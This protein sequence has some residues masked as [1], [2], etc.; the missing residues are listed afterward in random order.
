MISAVTS[1]VAAGPLDWLWQAI[2]DAAG[3]VAGAVLVV[4][5]S[6]ADFVVQGLLAHV[7]LPLVQSTLFAPVSLAHGAGAGVVGQAAWAVW[8]TAAAASPAVALVSLAWGGWLTS[9]F[10]AVGREKPALAEGLAVWALTLVGGYA[11]LQ[12]LLAAANTITQTLM[13]ASRSLLANALTASAHPAVDLA[14][15]V[16][17]V[18]T[19]LFQPLA[20]LILSGLLLW[21]VV[22]WVMRQ[23]EIVVFVGILPV[24]AALALSGNRRAWQWAWAE[25]QGAVFTQLAMAVLWWIAWLLLGGQLPSL[26]TGFGPDLGRLL[27]AAGALWMV[28]QA[29]Q[30]VR[31][32]TGHQH[33]G[34]GG[35]MLGMAAGALL[36]RNTR[37]AFHMS[38]MGAALHGVVQG[39]LAAAEQKALEGAQGPSLGERLA[40]TTV[41]QAVAP[42]W[43][44]LH[45]AAQELSARAV[46]LTDGLI[47]QMEQSPE[48][49]TRAAGLAL[50]G[51]FVVGQHAAPYAASAVHGLR[52]AASA[53][54]QP[55]VTAGR[56]LERAYGQQAEAAETTRAGRVAAATAAVGPAATQAQFRL[57]LREYERLMGARG[58]TDPPGF[59]PG[60]W[61]QGTY[62]RVRGAP[63]PPRG[64][65]APADAT[66]V[67]ARARAIRGQTHHVQ[68]PPPLDARYE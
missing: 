8:Q 7:V 53:V 35:L 12:A 24:T 66:P 28:T 26:A 59:N 58:A 63:A 19:F 37:N 49:V 18:L 20:G 31:A 45:T 1:V 3:A 41:G 32:I 4:L 16:G 14:N 15:G 22:Q 10:V 60:A 50:R 34:L 11:F 48:A 68:P 46:A 39:R 21:V 51:A 54:Y 27:L 43:Q 29:P 33:A 44:Q 64:A 5:G 30:M 2:A 25:A 38:P 40:G 42:R 56:A 9:G 13:A 17:L 62:Q 36:A 47:Q 57:P 52:T 23:V 61:Q 6:F 65:A 55:R 67:Q